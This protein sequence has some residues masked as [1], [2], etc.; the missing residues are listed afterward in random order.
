[1]LAHERRQVRSEELS[2]ILELADA[3]RL[4]G[5]VEWEEADVFGLFLNHIV[6]PDD[7]S[8]FVIRDR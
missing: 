3:G 2:K 1:M 5:L 6:D 7:V 4:W 8:F